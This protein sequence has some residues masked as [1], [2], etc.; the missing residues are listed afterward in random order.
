MKYL[1]TPPP[2]KIPL[3]LK[4]VRFVPGSVY[5]YISNDL[6]QRLKH[7]LQLKHLHCW[8]FNMP[9]RHTSQETTFFDGIT[10][11]FLAMC[12]LKT[13]CMIVNDVG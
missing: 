7:F 3:C 8:V 11:S 1:L 12:H 10:F 9:D 13:K 5:V 4:Y 2:Y 6:A